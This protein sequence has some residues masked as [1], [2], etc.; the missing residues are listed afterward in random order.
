MK[1]FRNFIM[2]GNLIELAVA[3]IIG[4]AFATVVTTFTAIIL[5]LIGKLGGSPDFSNYNPSNVPVGKF[6]TALVAFLILAL[7]VYFFIVKP[8][9]SL[10]ARFEKPAA[11]GD[12]VESLLAEIRDELRTKPTQL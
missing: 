10:K 9:E 1:G 7:V 5:A 3:F 12:T 4:G 2:R 8:Y 11:P 6:L